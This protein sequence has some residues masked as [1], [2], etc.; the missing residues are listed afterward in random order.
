MPQPPARRKIFVK[1]GFMDYLMKFKETP[2]F[3]ETRAGSPNFA[4]N[5]MKKERTKTRKD[6]ILEKQKNKPSNH[7]S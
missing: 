1:P 3:L 2:V 6:A 7:K 4:G 5:K